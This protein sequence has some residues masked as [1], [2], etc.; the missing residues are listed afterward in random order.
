MQNIEEAIERAIK[1]LENPWAAGPQGVVDAIMALREARGEYL[2]MLE[3]SASGK[4][5]DY[6]TL[7]AILERVNEHKRP[8]ITD[9]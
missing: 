8:E 9:D 7:D 2:R 5:D 3:S 6:Y 1:V 4:P